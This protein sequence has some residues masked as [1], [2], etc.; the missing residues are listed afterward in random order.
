[1]KV[2][3]KRVVMTSL[4]CFGLA[5]CG[6][7]DDDS[8]MTDATGS[9]AGNGDDSSSTSGP[10]LGVTPT[11]PVSVFDGTWVSNCTE[12][13]S[14]TGVSEFQRITLG[15]NADAFTRTINSYTDS[16]CSVAATPATLVSQHSMQFPEGEAATTQGSA[17]FVDITLEEVSV[18]GVDV[19]AAQ[20]LLGT[21]NTIEYNI[22]VVGADGFL[23]FGVPG[24]T[25]AD[26]PGE[27]NTNVFFE[28]Q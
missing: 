23:Y 7:D 5:A 4:L 16:D 17:P 11:D 8:G 27:L 13:L 28:L 6:S 1:M 19:T 25:A 3:I 10:A 2:D 20:Q 26:R 18:D 22:Y 15:V 21:T 12:E 9:D 24:L 14:L